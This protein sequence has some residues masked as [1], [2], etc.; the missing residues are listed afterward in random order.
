MSKRI[1]PANP[2]SMRYSAN[3]PMY[4]TQPICSRAN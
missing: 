1:L 2:Y 4:N 3:L